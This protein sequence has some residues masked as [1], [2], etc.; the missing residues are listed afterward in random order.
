[1]K[2]FLKG[3][4]IKDF[5]KGIKIKNLFK[6]LNPKKILQSIK[7]KN[8]IKLFGIK[9]L[10]IVA[11]AVT[12][13]V[14]ICYGVGA[15]FGGGVGSGEGSGNSEIENS[16][17]R[18]VNSEEVE[19]VLSTTETLNVQED[20]EL[21]QGEIIELNVVGND[22]FYNNERIALEGFL[23][24]ICDVEGKIIVEIKD[25]NASLKAYNAVLSALDEKNIDYIE[26]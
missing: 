10:L 2:K 13:V 3:M 21:L 4:K 15:G 5:F 22:Y 7:L 20:E 18:E 14:L 9:N 6:G 11:M 19:E 1:M 26:K 25:D 24:I 23:T 8:V 12:I 17:E 16:L